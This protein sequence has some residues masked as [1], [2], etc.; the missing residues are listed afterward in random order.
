MSTGTPYSTP[1]ELISALYS[2]SSTLPGPF[3]ELN[4]SFLLQSAYLVFFMHC[5]FA[6]LSIGC[7]RAKFAKHIAV[8]ILV[9]ATASALGFYLFGFAFAYGDDASADGLNPAGNAFIGKNFFAMNKMAPTAYYNWVFQWTGPQCLVA[10]TPDA[11]HC[12]ADTRLADCRKGTDINSLVGG[13]YLLFG[14]GAIDFAG[15]GAVHMVGGYAAF[16]GAWVLG[17]RIGRFLPDGTSVDMAGHNTSLFVLGVMILWFGWYGFNPGSQ[18]A[19]V[20]PTGSTYSIASAV[21]NAAV[22]TSLAP[23]AAGLTGLFVTAILLKVKTGK[24]HWDIMAMGNSTLAGLVAITAGCSTVYPWAAVTI[25]IVSGFIYPLASRL[26]VLIRIDDPLDA[27]AVHAFNGTWGVWAVGLFGAKNLINTSYGYNPYTEGDRHYGCFM[28][29]GGHLLAAQVV[30]SIWLGAWVLANMFTFFY[31]LKL[32]GYFRVNAADEAAGLDASHHGGSAYP[33]DLDDDASH[34]GS[35]YNGNQSGY[36]KNE[37]DSIRSELASLRQSIG[38]N[39]SADNGMS[40]SVRNGTRAEAMPGG[41][42][43]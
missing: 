38:K 2:T 19:I 20:T 39:R 3:Q 43:V 12:G 5:G 30:Y 28:G 4:E 42:M 9:D 10:A 11:V 8:L 31:V 13:G 33:M 16:A 32:L 21:S 25:G 18:L 6:M 36:N 34:K 40:D 41:N 24:H 7:V 1:E 15:S 14:S 27:I 29:G 23:A 37:L 22:T 17:P 26:M 35:S